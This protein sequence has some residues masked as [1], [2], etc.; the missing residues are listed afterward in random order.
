MKNDARLGDLVGPAGVLPGAPEDPLLLEPEHGRIGV[1]VVG[2]RAP[3][4]DGR[5]ARNLAATQIRR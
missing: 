1:P 4:G 3:V 5:H 2:E